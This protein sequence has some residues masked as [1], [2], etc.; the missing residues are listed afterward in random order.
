M[1]TTET[2]LA[3]RRIRTYRPKPVTD[4]LV[5]KLLEAAMSAPSAINE[6]PCHFVVITERELLDAI[7][8]YHPYSHM[9][10]EARTAILI[11]CDES[12]EVHKGYW[13]RDCAAAT[14]NILLAAQALGLGAIWV[15]VHHSA[16][17]VEATRK[18]LGIPEQVIPFALVP[19][20]YPSE[21]L[22]RTKR[23][24]PKRIHDNR[25]GRMKQN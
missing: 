14:E 21:R 18:L 3:W 20:G 17:R 25:W 8:K 19:L 2:N 13:E 22:P 7:P 24:N 12:L 9:L 4:E 15:G 6:H 5:T 1:E 23:F 16:A 10:H 11:C